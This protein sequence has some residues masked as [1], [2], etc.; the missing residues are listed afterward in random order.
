[1]KGGR[2][3]LPTCSA[4]VSN[5]EP[6]VR[7]LRSCSKISRLPSTRYARCLLLFLR[8]VAK[9]DGNVATNRPRIGRSND[10]GCH[11]QHSDYSILTMNRRA[12]GGGEGTVRDRGYV[13]TGYTTDRTCARAEPW[14]RRGFK[15]RGCSQSR[16]NKSADASGWYRFAAKP[17]LRL[18]FAASGL[19][20]PIFHHR[21]RHART[22][23]S[24]FF[25]LSAN[26]S[27][28]SLEEIRKRERVKGF[29]RRFCKLIDAINI[30]GNFSS[31]GKIF[32]VEDKY[33]E[34]RKRNCRGG[35]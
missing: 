3:P 4:K 8:L 28:R 23:I 18:H 6:V 9:L 16:I 5:F 10:S 30:D 13:T 19:R 29:R 7:P 17:G 24:F 25:F 12:T 1:M 34:S 15:G 35:E 27:F 33:C 11:W 14:W 21:S 20:H 22:L 26:P 2:D 32:Y 31:Y